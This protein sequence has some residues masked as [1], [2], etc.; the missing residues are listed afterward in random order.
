MS[1]GGDVCAGARPNGCNSSNEMLTREGVPYTYDNNGNLLSKTNGGGT[2]SYAWDFEN[3]LTSVTL[4]AGGVVSFKYDPFG[5]R[6]YKSSP[7]G[8]TI[9]VYDGNNISQELNG[10]GSVQERYTYGPGIDEPLVGQRQPK[11][12][13]YEADGLGSV[14][15]LTDPTGALAAT[16][17]Y[18]SFGFLTNSTGSATNWFRY[19]ARQFDSDTALYYCR[20]R[21]YDPSTGRFI[22]EDPIR[23]RGGINFYRYVRNNPIRFRDPFGMQDIGPILQPEPPPPFN[24]P[25]LYQASVSVGPNWGGTVSVTLTDTGNWYIGTGVQ[26]GKSP[27]LLGGSLGAFWA[28]GGGSCNKSDNLASGWSRTYSGGA[29]I[30][31]QQM[32]TPS[33]GSATGIAVGTPQGGGSFTYSEQVPSIDSSDGQGYAAPGYGP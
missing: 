11:I 27:W 32:F 13:F 31:V 3:R 30:L 26:A 22:S 24:P 25:N 23:F 15:S 14:T 28:N 9:Y 21:Y 18:D 2:T 5:R 20:A 29:G 1:C 12:F 8:T 33:G 16:Y 4:P 17:T 7:A 6:I 10:T 19:T